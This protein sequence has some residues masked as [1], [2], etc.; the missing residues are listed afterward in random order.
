MH[1]H[2]GHLTPVVAAAAAALALPVLP[3]A[4]ARARSNLGLTAG[5]VAA[6]LAAQ[7][8]DVRMPGGVSAHLLGGAVLAASLGT[9]LALRVMISVVL[10]QAAWGDGGLSTLGANILNIAVLP[11]L[12]TGLLSRGGGMLRSS[13]AA[14]VGTAVGVAACGIE[15]ALSGSSP[16]AIGWDGL[17]LAHA[18]IAVAEGALVA[19][20]F[21][22]RV[23]ARLGVSRA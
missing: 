18:P 13:T 4:F 14:V 3:I 21:A 11:V 1:L 19:A 12:V 10:A 7:A 23:P 5:A 15:L 2:D 9:S 8:L 17:Y 22:L 6:V 20:M 16:S